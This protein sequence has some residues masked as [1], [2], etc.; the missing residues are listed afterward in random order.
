MQKTRSELMEQITTLEQELSTLRQELNKTETS[1]NSIV[2]EMQRTETKQGKAK[3][4]V[5]YCFYV[6]KAMYCIN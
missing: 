3:W 2:S 5:I 4:V 1:I 6:Q